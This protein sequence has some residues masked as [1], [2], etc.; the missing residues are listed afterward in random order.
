MKGTYT[1]AGEKS[2]KIPHL[3][4]CVY[5]IITKTQIFFKNKTQWLQNCFKLTGNS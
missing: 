2:E 3:H 4:K 5:T 1:G